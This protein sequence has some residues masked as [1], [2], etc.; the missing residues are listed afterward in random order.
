MAGASA[1]NTERG[2]V[3]HLDARVQVDQ[4][5]GIM[6]L[7]AVLE[8]PDVV[9]T[10]AGVEIDILLKES[11]PPVFGPK[12]QVYLFRGTTRRRTKASQ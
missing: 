12:P 11:V 10:M 4:E 1:V 6:G 7:Q 8:Q 2:F 5:F 3:R 9:P